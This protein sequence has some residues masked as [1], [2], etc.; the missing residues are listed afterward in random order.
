MEE[1]RQQGLV[2]LGPD[3]NASQVNFSVHGAREIRFGLG[4]IKGTSDASVQAIIEARKNN[5][6]AFADIYAFVEALPPRAI[7][8][9]TMECLALSG[10]FDGFGELHRRQYTCEE[11]GANFVEKLL[12]YGQQ[13]KKERMEA[14]QSL[15]AASSYNPIKKPL[16]PP[17]APYAALEQLRIEKELIGCYITGHPLDPFRIDLK[18]FCN[19]TTQTVLAAERRDGTLAGILTECVVKQNSKGN[20]FAL[21]ALE[22]YHGSIKFSLFGEDYLKNKHFLQIGTLLFLKGSVVH[23]YGNQEGFV[24]KP[25]TIYLLEEIRA[26]MAKG[27]HLTLE[28]EGITLPL[29]TQ[30]EACMQQ[31][32]GK[33][34]V[35]ISIRDAAEE[36]VV[37]TCVQ[38]YRVELNNALVAACSQMAVDCRLY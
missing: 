36:W 32:P 34:P 30:L 33:S 10:A 19:V 28:Q 7:H 18:S 27:L 23:R 9:K 17:C 31:H 38:Q 26:K 4:A 3:V 8:K 2:L 22:D 1:S 35:K 24:F 12:Q 21:L 6:D 15:F 37:P 11:A 5:G 25:H 14:A 20:S 16:P 13:V 29:V